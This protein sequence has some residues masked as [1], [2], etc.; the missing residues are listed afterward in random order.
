MWIALPLFA[1]AMVF[2]M[3]SGLAGAEDSVEDALPISFCDVAE[4]EKYAYL[5]YA[6]ASEDEKAVILGARE[7]IIWQSS[8]SADGVPA[9]LTSPDGT[10][11]YLPYFHDIFPDDW[12]IPPMR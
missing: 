3:L 9:F 7:Y 5:D 8:W 12:E 11:T 4:A 2:V 6:S 1:A 10:V